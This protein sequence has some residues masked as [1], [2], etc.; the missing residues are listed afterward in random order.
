MTTL[1]TEGGKEVKDHP[2][3]PTK[4]QS[5]L[6]DKLVEGMDLDA[7]AAKHLD[8]P[9]REGDGEDDKDIVMERSVLLTI[10]PIRLQL[11]ILGK[12]R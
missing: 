10:I 2:L 4:E 5:D 1:K 11:L 3:L 12:Q 7:Y 8:D 6:M 9:A